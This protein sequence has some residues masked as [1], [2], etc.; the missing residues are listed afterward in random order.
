MTSFLIRFIQQQLGI[1]FV[2]GA[3]LGTRG[4]GWVDSRGPQ[5]AH[6]LAGKK[7]ANEESQFSVL[8][9]GRVQ[10]AWGA[11]RE[12]MFVSAWCKEVLGRA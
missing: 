11:H 2:P 12:G 1:Y 8:G 9:G 7:S 5:S 6:S 10:G 4:K 3:E